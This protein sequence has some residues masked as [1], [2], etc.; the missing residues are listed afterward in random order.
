MSQRL[1]HERCELRLMACAR[2]GKGLLELA[3]RCG[4]SDAHA[5]GGS[6]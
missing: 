4:K 5:I 3:P 2:L 1:V 6:L